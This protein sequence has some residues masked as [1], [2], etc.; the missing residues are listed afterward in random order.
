MENT[1]NMNA[2]I[3][4]VLVVGITLVIGI[5]IT[6]Q[7]QTT[8]RDYSSAAVV[9][10][11]NPKPTSAGISLNAVYA[12]GGACGSVTEIYNGTGGMLIG[13]GNITQSGC[14]VVNTTSMLPY[15]AN[16][17]W[18]YPYTFRGETNSSIAAGQVTDS[19]GTGAPWLTI[20]IVVSLATVV[21]GYLVNAYRKE[22]SK[23]VLY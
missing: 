7:L 1:K 10:E 5:Y 22:D 21:L 6:A 12:E 18:T 19:L 15:T 20:I 4:A 11:S 3:L 9:N 23:E 17:L 8:F 13:L 2:L 14:T 16:W